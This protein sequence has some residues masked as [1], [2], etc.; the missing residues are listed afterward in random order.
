M[1]LAIN[2]TIHCKAYKT[3]KF[4]NEIFHINIYH[5]SKYCNVGIV[6]IFKFLASVLHYI[7][8]FRMELRLN[9]QERQYQRAGAD[10]T[11][12]CRRW[13]DG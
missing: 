2:E 3:A 10:R 12:D 9:H 5:D 1:P 11:S 6:I 4:P 13:N 7:P 8:L